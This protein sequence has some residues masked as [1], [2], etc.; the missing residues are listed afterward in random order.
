LREFQKASFHNPAFVS[1]A[2]SDILL[3][4]KT[5][6][7]EAMS[8]VVADNVARPASDRARRA[9]REDI[10]FSWI[11]RVDAKLAPTD[12]VSATN[13]VLTANNA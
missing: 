7:V 8:P 11:S 6:D 3:S 5:G 1:P 10:L 9:R 13:A 12:D 2:V 4:A